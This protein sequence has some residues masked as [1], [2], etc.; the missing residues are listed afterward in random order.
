MKSL[1]VIESLEGRTYF[2]PLVF[3][4]ATSFATGANPSDVVAADLT[5]DGVTDVI[6][7]DFA[8]A[9]VAVLR[10]NG[11]GTFQS[12]VFYA[13][14]NSPE[15]LAVGD[16]NEDGIPDIVTANEGDNTIS[17]LMGNG[18][19]TFAAQQVYPVGL[20]PEA[21]AVA[22]LNGN[23]YSDIVV[24]DE[25]ASSVDVLMN[26]GN[27]TFQPAVSYAC[28]DNPDG[29]AVADLN[30][31]QRPDIVAINPL[32]SFLHVL[33]NK[34][35]GTFGTAVA[36]STGQTARAVAIADLNS[37]GR[38]DIITTSLHDTDINILNGNGDGTFQN[39]QTS[40][41]GFFPFSIAIADMNG[42]GRPDVVTANELDNTVS[43]LLHTGMATYL[44]LIGFHAGRAPVALA[45]ADLNGDGKPDII[46]ADFNTNS[47]S[48]LLNQ[49]KFPN[50]IPTTLTLTANQ[51]PVELHNRV[52]LTAQVMPSS[53]AGRR[54]IG[55]VQF[56]DGD[57]VLGVGTINAGGIAT[58]YPTKLTLGT[59]SITA[60]YSGDG[61]YK[62]VTSSPIME[63]VVE[64]NQT[65]PL[66]QPSIPSVQL[67]KE[68]VPGDRGVANVAITD[69]GD[70]P[71]VGVVGLQLY[72]STSSTF[73]STAFPIAIDGSSQAAV[74]L[75]GG[76]TVIDPVTF[77]MPTNIEPVNYTIFAVLSAVSGLTADQVSTMPAVGINS[78]VAVLEFGT[79]P[80]HGNYKLTRTLAGGNTVTLSLAGPGTGTVVEDSDGGISVA[81]S[82][83]AGFSTF[84]ISGSGVMLDSLTDNSP[85]GHVDASTTTLAGAMTLNGGVSRLTLAGG[86]NGS[87]FTGGGRADDLLLGTLSGVSLYSAAP[88]HSLAVNSW[89]NTFADGITTA[90]I[91]S[92]TSAG[93]FGPSLTINGSTG[94]RRLGISTATIGGTLGDATWSV[95]ANVGTVQV[96][97]VASGWSGS[98]HGTIYSLIDTGDFA[99]NLAAHNIGSVQISGDLTSADILAGADF[100][101]TARLGA[102]GDFFGHGILTSL[103]VNGSVTN[104]VVAAGLAPVGGVLLGPGTTLL[105][106]SAIR[107][108]TISGSV[109]TASKFLAVSLPVKASI[110]GLVVTLA[111]DANFQL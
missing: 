6:T 13:V 42:D 32:G 27:G 31:D 90:W 110:D 28:G 49:T 71:A 75:A 98:I 67:P 84:T 19:G 82:G 97:G 35:D 60:H 4:P 111:S 69:I 43:V 87:I 94:P 64:P 85:V 63:V 81:L 76:R 93:D 14:G 44:P 10:G 21:I 46:A 37:D 41:T 108:V 72:A 2:S 57:A 56:F 96:G 70:G 106:A 77:T 20:R 105:R 51:N 38:P 101:S 25:G 102:A 61:V 39:P 3:A 83:T 58:I 88:I 66:V 65:T 103:V 107:A 62:S 91:G 68:Y 16:F 92:I 11:D 95:Q 45:V 9:S 80:T 23:G 79:V 15:A 29:L 24:A 78:A 50:L 53:L 18:D 86:T 22:D 17:V 89:T 30:G 74:N 73:D 100:G 109:D 34:G 59:H 8:S 5:G 26:N 40:S 48:V 55:V 54:P 1:H 7:T 36:Y 104:S 33:L 52:V 47:I 12:P 99:G